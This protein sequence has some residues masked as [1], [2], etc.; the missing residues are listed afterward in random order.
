MTL[1]EQQA[2]DSFLEYEYNHA[3]ETGANLKLSKEAYMKSLEKL[4]YEISNS[5]DVD[6]NN[7]LLKGIDFS[8]QQPHGWVSCEAQ[9]DVLIVLLDAWLFAMGSPSFGVLKEMIGEAALKKLFNS[10]VVDLIIKGGGALGLRFSY[11]GVV[12]SVDVILDKLFDPGGA[13]ADWLDN[14]DIDKIPS[15]RWIELT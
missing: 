2:F 3:V 4:A 13:F 9:G 8:R 12:L 1:E 7:P 6:Y 5:K 11:A 14:S 10:E 15:N